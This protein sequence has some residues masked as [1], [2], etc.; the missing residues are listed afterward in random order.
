MTLTAPPQS[1]RA[2]AVFYSGSGVAEI[3]FLVISPTSFVEKYC[4]NL[5]IGLLKMFDSWIHAPQRVRGRSETFYMAVS[6]C[7]SVSRVPVVR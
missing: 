1:R 2:H 3:R 5:S 6:S 7:R 4:G